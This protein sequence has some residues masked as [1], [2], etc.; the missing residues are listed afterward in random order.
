MALDVAA[1]RSEREKLEWAFRLYDVDASGSINLK[2][3]AAIMVTMDNVEGRPVN[4]EDEDNED[5][6]KKSVE[7]Q[8]AELFAKLDVDDDGEI[9]MKEF[10]NGY[11]RLLGVEVDDD[12]EGRDENAEGQGNE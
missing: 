8:A 1:C 2:E 5:G 12:D 10:V 11:L 3:M 7:E 9:T 6:S 4:D